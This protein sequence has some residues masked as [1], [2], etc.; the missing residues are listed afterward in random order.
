MPVAPFAIGSRFTVIVHGH[1]VFYSILQRTVS[2][3]QFI[4]DKRLPVLT[5]MAHFKD[6]PRVTIEGRTVQINR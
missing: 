3:D 6:L 4:C 2:D 1:T 5:F